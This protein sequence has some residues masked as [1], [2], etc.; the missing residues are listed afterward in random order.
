MASNFFNLINPFGPTYFVIDPEKCRLKTAFN[1]R[2]N[3]SDMLGFESSNPYADLIASD[4]CVIEISTLASSWFQENTGT[5]GRL[6][7][8]VPKN[9]F[10]TRVKS[11]EVLIGF[12]RFV[13][14]MARYKFPWTMYIYDVTVVKPRRG[15]ASPPVNTLKVVDVENGIGAD[16]AFIKI[17]SRRYNK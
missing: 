9:V 11:L 16:F 10:S 4:F 5:P 1:F 7:I 14:G 3:V 6:I 15:N 13:E 8:G 12:L 2:R 17:R